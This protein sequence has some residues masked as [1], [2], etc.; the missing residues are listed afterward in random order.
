MSPFTADKNHLHHILNNIKQDEAF[1]VR[2]LI[3]IQLVF[4][5]MFLQLHHQDDA[6]NLLIFFLIFSIFFNLFDPRAKRRA[7]NA[8]LRKRYQKLKEEKKELKKEIKEA[9][10]FYKL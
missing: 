4:S 3:S 9:K 5:C 10:E 7:K 2:M 8:R 6:L 1:T